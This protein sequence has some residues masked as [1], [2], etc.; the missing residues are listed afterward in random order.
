[1]KYAFRDIYSG[2][3][4]KTGA[5]V[6]VKSGKLDC[7]NNKFWGSSMFSLSFDVQKYA[8]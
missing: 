1:M 7:Y 4:S 5:D 2:E 8:Y 3:T 6:I